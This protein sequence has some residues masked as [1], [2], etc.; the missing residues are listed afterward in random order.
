MLAFGITILCGKCKQSLV[1]HFCDVCMW[2]HL[3]QNAGNPSK[4]YNL[5]KKNIFQP[6]HFPL[7]NNS[8]F[9]FRKFE[10][11]LLTTR[12][13]PISTFYHAE[14]DFI[15]LVKWIYKPN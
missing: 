15:A 5:Q 10:C 7:V 2:H 3:L 6:S 1:R 9:D 12:M 4:V 11:K 14:A 8:S 13:H